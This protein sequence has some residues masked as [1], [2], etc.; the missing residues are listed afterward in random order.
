VFV[1]VS[2]GTAD[3]V[4]AHFRLAAVRVKYAPLYICQDRWQQQHQTVG[5]DTGT[6]AAYFNSQ[7]TGFAEI[8]LF[9]KTINQDK[10]IA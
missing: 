6:A 2:G 8:Q 9:F 10:V 4:A 1:Q 5:P 7:I 3:G